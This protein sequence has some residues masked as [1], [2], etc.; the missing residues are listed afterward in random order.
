V[1]SS[2]P[3]ILAVGTFFD[4]E[5]V[6]RKRPE[7]LEVPSNR[8]AVKVI[9]NTR[10]KLSDLPDV[11]ER[12]NIVS[13]ILSYHL[14]GLDNEEI[15]VAINL[16]LE[17]VVAIKMLEAFSKMQEAVMDRM[18]ARDKEEVTQVLEKAAV[19]GA[20]TIVHL[21]QHAEDEKVQL[22]A[23]KDVLDRNGHRPADILEVRHSMTNSLTIEHIVRS[24]DEV[25]PIIEVT[26]FEEVEHGDST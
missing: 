1:I 16:P 9:T 23:A 26:D 15:S 17:R 25:A 4:P 18:V 5:T 13:V 20:N 6:K 2:T 7:Y 3:L 19:T 8:E 24:D 21:M 10:R 14:F 22:T 11:P 12:M